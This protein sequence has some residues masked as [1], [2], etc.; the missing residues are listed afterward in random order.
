MAKQ[1]QTTPSALA[2]AWLLRHPAGIVPIIGATNPAHIADNCAAVDIEVT[3]QEWYALFQGAAALSAPAVKSA[4]RECRTCC[5][6]S[7]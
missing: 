1:K 5:S 6:F 7:H 4:A 3:R 2:L